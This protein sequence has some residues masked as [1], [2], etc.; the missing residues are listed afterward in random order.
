M[1]AYT[2]NRRRVL[3]ALHRRGLITGIRQAAHI[4]VSRQTLAAALSGART[5][6]ETTLRKL[7]SSLD[8]SFEDIMTAS[9]EQGKGLWL[10]ASR[11]T[12][13]ATM[14]LV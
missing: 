4:G 7:A 8:L 10:L 3:A 9:P 14:S 6:H 5:P 12:S 1:P 13:P 2:I 11:A